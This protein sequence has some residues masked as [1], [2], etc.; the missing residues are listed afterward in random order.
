M[1]SRAPVP[2]RCRHNAQDG[3]RARPST[4]EG[5]RWPG[6]RVQAIAARERVVSG[7][8][9]RRPDAQVPAVGHGVDLGLAVGDGPDKRD[10]VVGEIDM[11]E[12]VEL[13]QEKNGPSEGA[14]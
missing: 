2:K 11:E 4:T 6:A 3:A 12:G 1:G 14:R 8:R 10:P 5:W 9:I 7:C 13:S